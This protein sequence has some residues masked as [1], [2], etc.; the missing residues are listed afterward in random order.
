MRW[1]A[2]SVATCPSVELRLQSNPVATAPGTDP[3]PTTLSPLRGCIVDLDT[4]ETE[5]MVCQRCREAGRAWLNENPSP[6]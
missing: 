4:M 2:G 6:Y 1:S 3:G 5:A